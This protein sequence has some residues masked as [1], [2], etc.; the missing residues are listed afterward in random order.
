MLG[1]KGSRPDHCW[2]Q[3]T[4]VF[5]LPHS[6]DRMILSSF[7]WV[8]YQP[9]TDGQ[10]DRQTELPQLIQRS[11]FQA[12][13]PLCINSYLLNKL[14]FSICNYVGTQQC[15]KGTWVHVRTPSG[16]RTRRF[17]KA[18]PP[19]VKKLAPKVSQTRP[20]LAPP[21]TRLT[22]PCHVSQTINTIHMQ[23]YAH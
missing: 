5:L 22:Q 23:F 13:R 15:S 4:R 1:G 17:N 8:K 21:Q 16:A 6:E 3:K 18:K 10:T 2:Y 19:D 12:M 11:A 9:V 14:R 20:K 7:V